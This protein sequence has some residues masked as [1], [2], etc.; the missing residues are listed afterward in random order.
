MSDLISIDIGSTYTK[1]ALFKPEIGCFGLVKTATTATTNHLPDGVNKIYK[2]LEPELN[3]KNPLKV[4]FSS[5]AKGGL[6]VAVIGLVPEIT[7]S[8]ARLAAHSAGAK[9]TCSFPYK[10][11]KQQISELQNEKP[12]IILLS[13][14]TDGG[15]E[16]YALENAQKIEMLNYD[17]IVIF[18]GNK[19]ITDDVESIIKTKK[20][21]ITENLMPDFGKLNIEPVRNCIR[22]VFLDSIVD[23]KG[24]D[25]I[26][27]QFKS[28]PVPTPLAVFN[29]AKAIGENIDNWSDFAIID[30]GGA[31]TDCYSYTKSFYPDERKVLK[32]ILEPTLKRTVEG[33]LGMR[34]SAYSTLESLDAQTTDN[35]ELDFSTAENYCQMVSKST[36]FIPKKNNEILID[37]MLA[38]ICF[39]NSISRHAGF[40]EE[41]FTNK[42]KILA[43]TGKDLKNINKLICTGGYLSKKAKKPIKLKQN[44][45]SDK[46]ALLPVNVDYFID[47]QYILPLIANLAEEY[48]VLA[49]K[50]AV[51]FLHKYVEKKNPKESS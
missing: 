51:K 27:T 5:S 11:T 46:I 41:V 24:L 43:Q 25:K 34:V 18:A 48:P 44:V 47:S 28:N 21:H 36:D 22:Q 32:G 13:G 4:H 1:A 16:K 29:L 2:E 30:I 40:V 35:F 37:E 50:T 15:S 12:D 6:R 7:L 33:D 17:P 31:T 26:I 23:G 3:N 42:G 8:I 14:G 9:I 20:L 38:E 19:Y 49:A 39:N 10:L 45:C